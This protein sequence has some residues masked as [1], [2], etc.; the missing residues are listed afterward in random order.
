M[1]HTHGGLLMKSARRLS[2]KTSIHLTLSVMLCAVACFAA[3]LHGYLANR[4]I[5]EARNASAIS[6]AR[7]IGCHLRTEAGESPDLVRQSCNRLIQQPGVLA[8][9]TWDQS[10]RMT[11]GASVA[12]GLEKSLRPRCSK[13]VQPVTELVAIPAGLLPGRSLARRVEVE[14]GMAPS[15]DGPARICLLLETGES[16]SGESGLLIFLAAVMAISLLAMLA[17][18]CWLRREVVRPIL[19]LLHAATAANADGSNGDLFARQDE[20]GTI[21][22]SLV[23]LQ[24]DLNEWRRRAA[25]I[26]RRMGSQIAAETQRITRELRRLQR[27]N[28]LDP[29][30]E[31][32]NRR[33]LE[34]KFASIFDAQRDARHDL[35]VIMFD[36]DRFKAVNDSLGHV[37]GDELLKFIGQLLRQCRRSDDFA[38]R[39]GGDE[40]LMVLPGTSAENAKALASRLLALFAQRAKMI[41][42]TRPPP[43]LSA[44]VASIDHDNP[45]TPQELIAAADRALY[46]AKERGKTVCL[47]EC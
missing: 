40:F 34:K 25:L 46:R 20:L 29:L 27:Q 26:E 15:L 31:V 5:A 39:Y 18:S 41:A 33:F 37:V 2:I 1:V 30:T 44:G 43:A 3:V 36:I 9:S 21:A 47:A 12:P 38:V 35:S 10:G 17:A 23:G 14:S 24:E 4:N 6:M 32:H 11:A 16:N 8:V 19:S 45:S 22:R 7:V 28:W 42:N 13:A